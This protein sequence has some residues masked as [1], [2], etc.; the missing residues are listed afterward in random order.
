MAPILI[1]MQNILIDISGETYGHWVVLRKAPR[2]STK[3]EA[4]WVC[5]C[6]C[7]TE[8][9]VKSS[10]LRDGTAKSCGCLRV[11]PG[12]THG[13]S[14]SVEHKTWRG[15]LARCYTE[16]NHRYPYYGGRGIVVSDEWRTNFM[17]FY[18][19][20][21]PRP[22]AL[23]SLERKENDGPYDKDN[24]KWA[25]KKEQARN[26]RTSVRYVFR[27]VAATLPEWSE[28]LG[29]PHVTLVKRLERGLPL[30]EVFSTKN[31]RTGRRLVRPRSALR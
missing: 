23:H 8:K 4:T 16:T 31:S 6:V 3:Q 13:L 10:R 19:D 20:M 1:H 29:V 12:T 18:K 27:G 14:A 7:G 2:T 15:M 11:A 5:R 30:A 17:Q 21:G 22:S 26:R 25:T 28:R 9:I 24:C